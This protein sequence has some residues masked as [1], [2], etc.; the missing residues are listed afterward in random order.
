[1]NFR[2]VVSDPVSRVEARLL[3]V[4]HDHGRTERF[5]KQYKAI[6][7]KL[8]HP[9]HRNPSQPAGLKL[10]G[11]GVEKHLAGKQQASFAIGCE[12]ALGL[13]QNFE[14]QLVGTSTLPRRVTDHAVESIIR[15]AIISQKIGAADHGDT[16]GI[17]GRFCAGNQV[18]E[19]VFG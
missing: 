15:Q 17:I 11:L 6:V 10:V 18:G 8:D 5:F 1:M 7:G 16:F 13:L 4:A 3:A 14:G 12:V 9:L 2:C 19:L